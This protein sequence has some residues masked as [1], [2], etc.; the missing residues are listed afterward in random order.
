[1]SPDRW[2]LVTASSSPRRWTM[3]R[4]SP[5]YLRIT[6]A[7]GYRA[8]RAEVVIPARRERRIQKLSQQARRPPAPSPARPP[9]P[10]PSQIGRYHMVGTLGRAAWA[11][12]FRVGSRHRT[13]RRHQSH[14]CRNDRIRSMGAVPPAFPPR[15]TDCGPPAHPRSSCSSTWA[16]RTISLI[17]SWSLCLERASR[18]ISR[19]AS[20]APSSSLLATGCCERPGLRSLVRRRPS[21]HQAWQ[22]A[23]AGQRRVKMTDFGIARFMSVDSHTTAGIF[24][25]TIGYVA[26]EIGRRKC[27]TA[28]RINTLSASWPIAC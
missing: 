6:N 20:P 14:Q 19:T 9:A 4:P 7:A 24:V 12:S 11:R 27:S 28:G 3:S 23:A 13:P 2:Q 5:T 1:M 21:R 10:V 25:G 22:P 15:S 26:P 16:S 18:P 8:L 17:W